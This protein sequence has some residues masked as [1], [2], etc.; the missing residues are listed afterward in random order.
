MKKPGLLSSFNQIKFFSNLIL[1]SLIIGR[2]EPQIKT[3][4]LTLLKISVQC[5]I[6]REGNKINAVP[7]SKFY[8]FE[9]IASNAP[10]K[11]FLAHALG[12]S[13]VA[14]IT[15]YHYWQD[16]FRRFSKK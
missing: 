6:C 8:N 9:A 10:V 13:P 2:E 14:Q 5:K 7:D 4:L 11:V 1:K 15:F 3:A 16:K 12:S